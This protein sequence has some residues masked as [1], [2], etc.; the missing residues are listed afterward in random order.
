MIVPVTSIGS[1]VVALVSIRRIRLRGCH[2]R[3]QHTA[4][5]DN[6]F[7]CSPPVVNGFSAEE[8]LELVSLHKRASSAHFQQPTFHQ[9]W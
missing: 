8:S 4:E 5:R 6:Y 3:N 2:Q 7:S 1:V 9:R